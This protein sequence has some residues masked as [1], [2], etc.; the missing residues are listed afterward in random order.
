MTLQ[1][2]PF[3]GS[4]EAAGHEYAG[5]LKR[6]QEKLL[7]AKGELQR[8]EEAAAHQPHLQRPPPTARTAWTTMMTTMTTTLRS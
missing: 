5:L 7:R 6:A 4:A 3:E 1:A 8:L 2:P